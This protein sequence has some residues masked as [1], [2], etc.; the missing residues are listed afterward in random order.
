MRIGLLKKSTVRSV[1]AK[2]SQAADPKP[3]RHWLVAAAACRSGV[4]WRAGRETQH[5]SQDAAIIPQQKT[6]MVYYKNR[7]VTKFSL[8][9]KTE[10]IFLSS[11]CI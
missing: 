1:A 5:H 3:G 9:E 4:L 2:H 7:G 8:G 6:G 10:Q 11:W